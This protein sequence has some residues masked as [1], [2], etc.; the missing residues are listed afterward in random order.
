MK[1]YLYGPDTVCLGVVL[2]DR[3]KGTRTL[4]RCPV[5]FVDVTWQYVEDIY[6][7]KD[8]FQYDLLV[9]LFRKSV[10]DRLDPVFIKLFYKTFP[11]QINGIQC[12]CIL[13]L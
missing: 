2:K 3:F 10:C 6:Y 7:H 5:Y 11:I 4:H 1:L 13:I 8:S 9:Q 12:T